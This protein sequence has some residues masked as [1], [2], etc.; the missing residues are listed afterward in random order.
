MVDKTAR[1]CELLIAL[2]KLSGKDGKVGSPSWKSCQMRGLLPEGMS[3]DQAAKRFYQMR[4]TLPIDKPVGGK[5]RGWH[6]IKPEE[7]QLLVC[8]A[9][10]MQANGLFKPDWKGAA[11]K[12]YLPNGMTSDKAAKVWWSVKAVVGL[13][14]AS[15][16]AS[17]GTPMTPQ[18]SRTALRKG[19]SPTTTAAMSDDD[20]D[21]DDSFEILAKGEDHDDY[22][23]PAS[24]R[25]ASPSAPHDA[26]VLAACLSDPSPKRIK[27]S[28][29][30][31]SPRKAKSDASIRLLECCLKETTDDEGS[32]VGANDIAGQLNSFETAIKVEIPVLVPPKPRSSEGLHAPLPPLGATVV[33]S[34]TP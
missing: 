3:T 21:D 31:N 11:E 30:R 25:Q 20:D 15:S 17:R 24:F 13:N 19:Y 6:T 27:L 10:V 16:S 2:A 9:N 8:L 1:A 18:K 22:P 33:R 14:S 23:V 4:Q 29:R 7:L 32:E 34:S 26:S 12:G 28:P 5:I